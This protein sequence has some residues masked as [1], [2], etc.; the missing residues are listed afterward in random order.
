MAMTIADYEQNGSDA[1]KALIKACREGKACKLGPL[2]TE[3]DKTQTVRAE[4]IRCL[5]LKETSLHEAGVTLHGARILGTLDLR[6]GEYRG[7]LKLCICRFDGL[8]H[9]ERIELDALSLEGS[10]LPMGL[11]GEDLKVMRGLDLN[12][13]KSKRTVT[14]RRAEIG[15]DLKC[16]SA[17]FESALGCALS[18]EYI[19]IGGGAFFERFKAKSAV[20]LSAAVI[21]AE[22]N[23]EGASF[24]SSREDVEYGKALMTQGMRV[25]G[26]FVCQKIREITGDIDLNTSH[27][28]SLVDDEGGWP[29]CRELVLDGFTYDR[30]AGNIA[31]KSLEKR[32]AWLEKGSRLGSEFFPQPGFVAQIP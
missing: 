2:P 30:I 20:N 32:K 19:K 4:L 26:S 28:G 9:L 16:N 6:F 24:E 27:V 1:E 29:K 12:C 15:S 10:F 21:G 18:A 8:L 17:T 5:A 7:D 25:T 31:P 3:T 23:L 14:L 13:V 22:L 11:Y